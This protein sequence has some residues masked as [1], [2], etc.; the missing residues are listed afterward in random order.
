MSQAEGF[1]V[2][3]AGALGKLERTPQG[4]YVA[5]A[6][7]M[8]TGVMS[9][10]TE[11]LRKQGLKVPD[12]VGPLTRVYLPPDVLEAAAASLRNCPVTQ[13]HPSSFVTTKTF[14]SV[15][16]GT[17][18]NETINFDG[19]YM[20]A[21]LAIQDGGLIA[22]IDLGDCREVSMGYAALTRIEDGKTPS[23]EPYD[24]IR[25]SVTL[26]HAAVV[27]AGRAGAKVCLALDSAEIPNEEVTVKLK[28]K[29]AEVEITQSVIDGLEAEIAALAAEKTKA[30]EAKDAAEA[31]RVLATSDAALDKLLETK[32]AAKVAAD[33]KAARKAAVQKAYP[34][35]ALDGKSDDFVDGLHARLEAEDAADPDGVKRLA[36]TLGPK[37]DPLKVTDA[38]PRVSAREKMRAEMQALSNGK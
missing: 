36:G 19:E 20:H 35:I 16:K 5:P 9:Y 13:G 4:G 3:S 32:T 27:G 6:R 26:N 30:V 7:V 34:T 17:V 33:A 22:S 29:G 2:D 10:P 28:I 14:S 37:T 18:V 38:K 23:G 24:A 11:T 8:R 31:A 21:S 1:F 12:H 25:A 15:T